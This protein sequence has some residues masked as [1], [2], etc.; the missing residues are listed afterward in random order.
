MTRSLL[1]VRRRRSRASKKYEPGRTPSSSVR[2][3]TA[4]LA[5]AI[6]LTTETAEAFLPMPAVRGTR[7][8]GRPCRRE[9]ASVDR[10]R[11]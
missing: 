4:R 6:L 7:A 3:T 9:N 8:E 5:E 10:R 11:G 1:S 2:E